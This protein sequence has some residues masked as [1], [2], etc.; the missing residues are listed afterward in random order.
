MGPI[1]LFQNTH[2]E[3]CQLPKSGG[4]PAKGRRGSPQ[5]QSLLNT[6]T[7]LRLV[8]MDQWEHNRA[9]LVIRLPAASSL[10]PVNVNA[11]GIS[12]VWGGAQ[13]LHFQQVS[14]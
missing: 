2:F 9:H 12:V 11:L 14:T 3:Q 6:G 4:L 13:V 5:L 7:L 10:N 8:S 1:V